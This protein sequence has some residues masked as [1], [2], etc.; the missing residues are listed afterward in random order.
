MG[1]GKLIDMKMTISKISP[2]F[3]AIITVGLTLPGCTKNGMPGRDSLIRFSTTSNG[4]VQTKTSY[5]EDYTDSETKKTFQALDWETG[6]LITIASPHATVQNG[7]GHMSDY[8]VTVKTKGSDK[9]PKSTGSVTDVNANGLMWNDEL[10]KHTFYAIYPNSSEKINIDTSGNVTATIPPT[11]V[12]GDSMG[13]KTYTSGTGNDAVTYKYTKYKP[14]MDRAFMTASTKAMPEDGEINLTFNPAFT[15]FEI[16]VSSQGADVELEKFMMVSKSVAGKEDDESFNPDYLTGTFKMKAGAN[17]SKVSTTDSEDL[18][19]QID[20]DLSG[21]TVKNGEGISFTVFT[22]PVENNN[23]YTIKFKEKGI[24]TCVLK[25]VYGEKATTG[26]PGAP[27]KFEAGHKYRIN[28][29]KLPDHKWKFTIELENEVLEWEYNETEADYSDQIVVA[30]PFTPVSKD[31]VIDHNSS[32][33]TWKG[34]PIYVSFQITN[35]QNGKWFIAPFTGTASMN[36]VDCHTTDA[37]AFKV[38]VVEFNGEEIVYESESLNGTI[39]G[40]TNVILKIEPA[41]IPY[42]GGEQILIL[43]SSV[44]IGGKEFNM[45]SETQQ[46]DVWGREG[47]WKFIIPA[48]D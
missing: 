40:V 47:Y 3:I 13:E 37:T 36:L 24:G 25:L 41:T 29:L 18:G 45:D 27:V 38:T 16:N 7:T 39:S 46:I 26:T 17:L 4:S 28:A 23:Y 42:K 32:T 43:T 35:P 44:E 31:A 20:V 48:Q 1:M 11:Q 9:D 21:K 5:G 22:L 6:D 8:R 30:T 10:G 33:A 19:N 12:L 15:A 34:S 2:V 14:M